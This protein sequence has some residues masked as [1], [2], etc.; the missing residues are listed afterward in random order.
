M[1]DS[2]IPTRARAKPSGPPK[3]ID[4]M[5]WSRKG[6]GS[7][8]FVWQDRQQSITFSLYT[9][10]ESLHH[11][12]PFPLFLSYTLDHHISF[13]SDIPA[14]AGFSVTIFVQISLFVHLVS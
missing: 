6:G 11:I 12:R 2:F 7:R 13:L 10:F 14:T 8:F 5:I 1:V 4:L 3:P 9:V